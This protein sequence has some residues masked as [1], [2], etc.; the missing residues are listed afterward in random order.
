MKNPKY[1]QILNSLIEDRIP[2]NLDL[3]PKI[4][5]KI[6]MQKGAMMNRRKKVLIPT[7]LA[8]MVMSVITVTVPAVADTLQRWIGYIPGFG[9]VQDNAIITLAEPQSQTVNGITVIVN[10]LT[11]STDKTLVEYT[12][13]GIDESMVSNR[14]VCP[15]ANEIALDA[16]PVIRLTNGTSLTDFSLGV[17]P[18]N[19]S[20]QFEAAYSS[21]IPADEQIVTFNLD[22]LWKTK[23]GSEV[24][25]FQIP[26]PL[27][28]KNAVE[29]TVA[30]LLDIPEQKT[31]TAT[32]LNPV[33]EGTISAN[34]IIP[35]TNGYILQGWITVNHEQGLTA[36]I[37]NGYIEDMTI[38][39]A[40]NV[41]LNSSMV[42]NDFI[43]EADQV[44]DNQYPWAMQIN[45][46][47][48]AW[49]I[50]L[51]VNSIPASTESYAGSMFQVDVGTDPQPGQEW[52]IDQDVPLGPKMV[53]VVSIRRFMDEMK[54]MNGY[55]ITFL[56][57]P[58]L[59]FSF[60][61]LGAN[62]NGGGGGGGGGD[63]GGLDGETVKVVESYM[64]EVPTGLLTVQLNGFGIE[65]INGPWQVI[66]DKP[67][68]LN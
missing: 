10:E 5:S 32:D 36:D 63:G 60:D 15:M 26:L 12:I 34:Q 57:D 67:E 19:R 50:T 52:I 51:K 13:T 1:S 53:H 22:C 23:N 39:D 6:Q 58:T 62:P 16:T 29:L 21:P 4:F 59:A 45:V 43:V 9:Q 42:P 65:T 48:V 24:W 56:Y 7:A 8:I 11:A 66:L 49:P 2:S 35:L 28:A 3:A 44:Q 41:V 20:Y 18:G 37:F 25:S 55:E 64:G 46:S 31:D 27:V 54:M 68:P 14:L 30:P 40:N 47:E 61:I 38:T 33:V 17:K